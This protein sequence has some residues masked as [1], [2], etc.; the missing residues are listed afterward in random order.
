MTE[1]LFVHNVSKI[2]KSFLSFFLL[3]IKYHFNIRLPIDHTIPPWTGNVPN[4]IPGVDAWCPF[5]NGSDLTG[6]NGQACFW[7]S[8]GCSIGC[9]ECDGTTRGPIPNQPEFAHKNEKCIMVPKPDHSVNS[10]FHR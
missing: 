6:R 7:F 2:E 4:P 9:P 10:M 5:H 8:N 3:S 1:L